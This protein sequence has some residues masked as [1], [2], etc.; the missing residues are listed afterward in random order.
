M[1]APFMFAGGLVALFASGLSDSA[2]AERNKIEY[3]KDI[4]AGY[5]IGLQSR[6]EYNRRNLWDMYDIPAT[7][8]N[9]KKEFPR[10]SAY[11]QSR[12]AEA[13]AV[14]QRMKVEGYK[15]KAPEFCD[16][17]DLKKYI[18]INYDYWNKFGK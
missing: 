11:N 1:L 4:Q 16:G 5:N 6:I 3:N 10:M 17:F 12:L 15:Y 9:F 13:A 8:G 7:M 2:K 18:V 14:E